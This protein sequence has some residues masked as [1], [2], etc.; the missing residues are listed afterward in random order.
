VNNRRVAIWVMATCGVFSFILLAATSPST[1]FYGDSGELIAAAHGL[2]VAHPPGYPLYTAIGHLILRIPA[3]SPAVLLNLWSAV[4]AALCCA[5]IAG[6]IHR[7]T[8]SIIASAGAA[9][10]LLGSATFWSVSTIAEVYSLHLLFLALLLTLASMLG[11][12]ERSHR[13]YGALV[14]AMGLVLGLALSHRLTVLLVLPAVVILSLQAPRP[15]PSSSVK[16]LWWAVFIAVALPVFAYATL[17]LRARSGPLA[18]WGSPTDLPRLFAHISTR[19]YAN[20]VLGPANWFDGRAWMDVG[21]FVWRELG[22]VGLPLALYGLVVGLRSGW[23]TREGR[24][25]LAM[26]SLAVPTLLFGMSYATEDVEVLFLPLILAL[27]LAAGLG[28]ARAGKFTLLLA[29][30]LGSTALIINYP[31]LDRRGAQS[32]EHFGMDMLDTLPERSVLFTEGDETFLLSYLI[33]VQGQ[34]PD[35]LIFDRSGKLFR[36]ELLEPGSIPLDSE[37]TQAFRIRRETEFILRELTASVP[38]PVFFMS[39]PGYDLPAGLRFEPLGLFYRVRRDDELPDSDAALWH[40]YHETEIL[41]EAQRLQD[42][43]GLTVAAR[44]PLMRGE[45][46]L[47]MGDRDRALSA[48]DEASAVA[49]GSESIHNYLGTIFGRLGDYS[50]AIREFEEA[51][52]IKPVSVR[53]WNNLAL[54]RSLSGDG[55]GARAAWLRSLELDP[56]QPDIAG[57]L[58]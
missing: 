47:F 6:L 5:L 43:G 40:G 1:V 38:R 32:A 23:R 4:C 36:N 22:Y 27:S 41:A 21:R 24:V 39:W 9:C 53:A 48:F 19:S 16:T 11:E 52:R 2:G 26:L 55:E 45:R 49:T 51:L 46:A 50:R 14:L 34:R 58:K 10:G 37:S 15:R 35:L 13:Q 7:W 28:L 18:N 56:R 29:I 12:T 31:V 33:Q 44:Y 17:I 8:A 54:A 20:Y 3:I 42:R 57:R 30:V 25:A